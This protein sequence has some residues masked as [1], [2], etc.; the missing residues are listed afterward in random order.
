MSQPSTKILNVE[1]A[2][3]TILKRKSVQDSSVPPHVQA[4][5][6]EMFGT[7]TTPLQCVQAILKSVS[8][9]GDGAVA[10]WSKR[11]D[12]AD[13][14]NG[15]EMLPDA[16]DAALARIDPKLASAMRTAAKRIE[17]FHEA[18]PIS[19]WFTNDLGGTVGQAIRP[20][21]SVGVYAPG[22]TAPLPSTVLMS[23]I[24]A[25]VA[26]VK[27]IVVVS[28]PL[29]GTS[30][31]AIADVTIAAVAVLRE[32][33]GT[34]A[35]VRAFAVGGAQAIGALAYGTE[36]IPRVD[37]IVGPGNVFVALAK[38][39]VFGD[40]GIDGV[41][42]PTEALVV[43][44]EHADPELV[45]ADL[46][47]Q[48][49][50][51]FMAVPILVT[52]S[53]AQAEAV[54]AA[55][56]RQLEPL[57]RAKVARAAL[58]DQGGIVVARDLKECVQIS[59]EFAAEHVSLAVK[60][61]WTILADIKHAGGV[62]LGEG[63]CEVLGDYVAGPS[64]VMPTGGTARYSSP[65]SVLDFIK[66]VSVV[67]LDERTVREVAPQAEIIARAEGLDAHANAAALRKQF[68]EQ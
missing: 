29:R 35:S 67:A 31:P 59:N 26:G 58:K 37:K 19:S 51:D 7:P 43:A 20:I 1:D 60:N 13:L 55:V 21:D 66:V 3:N 28:P 36:S 41:Y 45:A 9:K 27:N 11:I 25:F 18:Q 65:L 50:H 63:S 17:A 44:D 64:H 33:T 6:D 42:G 53:A 61:P 15:Y 68:T 4:R 5:I 34:R 32:I 38:K 23:A 16:Q 22:G 49:E 8:D 52:N 54:Q 40:V 10:D 57:D 12:G 30:P 2:R 48:A 14:R 62:F 46:L 24:P 47:A 56:E 39:E